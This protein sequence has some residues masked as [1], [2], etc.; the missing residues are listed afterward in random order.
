MCCIFVQHRLLVHD[1]KY[2]HIVHVDKGD[3]D[4]NKTK[5]SVSPVA[6]APVN[7][8]EGLVLH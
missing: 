6:R 8:L 1:G 4:P 7:D 5:A 3:L 2:P